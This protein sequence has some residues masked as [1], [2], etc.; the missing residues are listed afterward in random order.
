MD[1]STILMLTG[2]AYQRRDHL[3]DDPRAVVKHLVGH[4]AELRRLAG[5]LRLFVS[6]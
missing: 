6:E 1:V 3:D 5:G 2:S 4:G